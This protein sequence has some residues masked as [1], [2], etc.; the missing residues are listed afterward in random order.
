MDAPPLTVLVADDSAIDRMILRR[1]LT[2]SG[3]RVLEAHDG[4]EAVKVFQREAPDLVFLDVQMPVL[5]GFEAA[6]HIKALASG[7]FVSVIFLSGT[8]HGPDIA[9]GIDA[10]GDDFL[11]KPYLP[12]L[13]RAKIDA[14]LR[15]RQI[16]DILKAQNERLSYHQELLRRDQRVAQEL[17]AKLFRRGRV[18]A[19]NV[20]SAVLP[21]AVFSGDLFLAGF[22]PYG[23][24]R[25]LLGDFTGHGLAAAV[26]ALPTA[27]IFHAMTDKGFSLP[28]LITETHRRLHGLLPKGLFLAAC[29]VEI[30]AAGNA[31]W[32]WNGGVPSALLWRGPGRAPDFLPSRHLPLG[33]LD[34]QELDTSLEAVEI[35]PGDRIY[36]CSDGLCEASSPTGEAFGETRLLEC[37]E[38][39]DASEGAFDAI[40]REHAAFRASREQG[41]DVTIAEI[42]FQPELLSPPSPN[43]EDGNSFVE[44]MDWCLSLELG[45]RSLRT[46]DPVPSFVQK[47]DEL[48]PLGAKKDALYVVVAELFSNALEHGVLGLDS[49]IKSTPQG[50]LHYYELRAETLAKLEDG[51]VRIEA[52]QA[53]QD[54][55]SHVR[56]RITDSGAGFDASPITLALAQNK[57]FSGRGIQLVQGLCQSLS[58]EAGGACAEAVFVG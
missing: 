33:I 47:I 41:D 44:P 39:C 31:M 27:E 54:D 24:Q 28:Q 5:D 17:L 6:R 13:L 25:F 30:Q 37:F 4:K 51:H 19:A 12:V 7:R 32:V 58:Y 52:W 16:H 11:N 22:T 42:V 20:R 43:A 21:A 9:K 10:G 15:L 40:L 56:L 1:M 45:A 46:A 18:D 53:P 48:H 14:F 3:H 26:G 29:Y 34:P 57:S 49:A 50:F 8:V 23:N 55:P 36:L 2:S 35:Q 38:R